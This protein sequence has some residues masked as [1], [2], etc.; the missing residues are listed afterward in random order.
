MTPPSSPQAID[1][2]SAESAPT[3]RGGERWRFWRAYGGLFALAVL[4]YLP[5]FRAGFIWNDRDY[6]TSPPLQSVS[7]LGRIWA[8]V[9][10]TEQYYPI[11]HSAFWLEH[12]LWGDAA[13]GYHW[14]NVLLHATSACLLL[15]ILRRLK[16]PGSGLA[17]TLFVVHPVCV[18]SVA[19]IAEQKN[20]LSTAFYLAALLAYVSYDESRSPRA[21]LRASVWFGFAL[22]SKS[23]TATLPAA[24]LVL[25]WWRRGRIDWQR[26][27]RPILPWFFVAAAYGLFTAWVERTYLGAG[28][29]DFMLSPLQRLLLAPR[30]V[31]F[32]FA[33][34]VWPFDLTFIYPRWEIDSSAVSSYLYPAALLAVFGAL[35]SLRRRSRAPL[36]VGLFFVGSLFPVLGFFNVYGFVFSYVADH[37]QYLPSLG[38]IVGASAW[39]TTQVLPATRRLGAAARVAIMAWLVGLTIMAWRQSQTYNDVVRFYRTIIA[40]NPECWMAYNNLGYH[41]AEAGRPAEAIPLFE[42]AQR[43]RPADADVRDNLGSA[44]RAIGRERDALACYQEAVRLRPKFAGARLHLAAT[45][46]AT[47]RRPE[48]I[49][50]Y[51]EILRLMP[52]SAEIWNDLGAVYAETGKSADAVR[53]YDR[54]VALKPDF[55]EAHSNLA[56]ALLQVGRLQ[57]AIAAGERAV[58]LR[59]N[60]ADGRSNL[61]IALAEAQR[62]DEAIVQFRAAV[63]LQPT[64]AGHHANLGRALLMSGRKTEAEAEFERARALAASR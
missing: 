29:A 50:N 47:G 10:A 57:E 24:C 28:G 8:D 1:L 9:G 18:E 36:A 61:G 53:C 25:V 52:D 20:T 54:A 55:A 21:Y 58:K 15:T 30:I 44:L 7:G 49:S 6:V 34:L 19:W 42:Q 14:A 5:V 17:A 48:A 2:P 26:E 37:W 35:W 11:L 60:Y 56:N 39:L 63:Q 62:V 46:D 31:W 40:Q 64:S 23:V 32:Y 27:V 51:E 45:L 13:A 16:I 43:L 59:P 22:L 3:K 33:K 41:F 4:V 12:R 38:L